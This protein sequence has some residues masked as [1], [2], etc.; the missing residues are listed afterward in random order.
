MRSRDRDAPT[1]IAKHELAHGF[2]QVVLLWHLCFGQQDRD[3]RKIALERGFDLEAHEIGGVVETSSA[4]LVD[5]AEPLRSNYRKQHVAARYAALDPSTEVLAFRD[6]IDVAKQVLPWELGRQVLEQSV[7]CCLAVVAAIRNENL[8]RDLL[9]Q[10]PFGAP[11]RC[12]ARSVLRGCIAVD[13]RKSRDRAWHISPP[14][15]DKRNAGCS[16]S[17][18]SDRDRKAVV[19]VPRPISGDQNHCN[20]TQQR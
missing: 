7:C 18:R 12:A 17:Q 15:L 20:Q 10:C 4:I 9:L 6:A 11:Q 1:A 2:G 5:H 14:D 3:D 19:D 8:R 13:R 16:N